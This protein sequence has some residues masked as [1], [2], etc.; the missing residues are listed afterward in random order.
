MSSV[1]MIRLNILLLFAKGNSLREI[2]K[3]DS[4]LIYI[5]LCDHVPD[6]IWVIVTFC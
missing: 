3:S 1:Q 2:V 5:L 4:L 6:S